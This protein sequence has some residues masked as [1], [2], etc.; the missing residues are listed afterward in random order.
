[1]HATG[2]ISDAKRFLSAGLLNTLGTLVLYQ[3]L[4]FVFSASVSYAI[5]WVAGLIFVAVVYPRHV[6]PGG[7]MDLLTRAAVLVAYGM[8]FGLGVLTIQVVTI[9]GAHQ[10]IAVLF[11]LA[12]TTAFNFVAMR[13]ILRREDRA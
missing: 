2:I 8:G 1:M 11:A 9:D 10:R 5:C 12:V 3:L 4:V 6:F 7:R 13:L